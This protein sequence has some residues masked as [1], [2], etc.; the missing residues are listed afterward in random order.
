MAEFSAIT[1]TDHTFNP[2]IGCTK[3]GPGCDACYAEALMD[4]RYGRVK[5]GH[6]EERVRTKPQNWSKVRRWNKDAAAFTAEH[7][8]LPRVF[9]ASLADVFDNEVS[10]EWRAD[11]LALI[12]SARDLRWT[13]VTK[14][15]G[16]ARKML[17]ATWGDGWPHVAIAPTIVNQDEWDRDARKLRDLPAAKRG[18]SLEPLIG[19]I[20]MR[21][22]AAASDWLHWVIVGGESQQGKATPRPMHAEWARSLRDQSQCAGIAFHM[23]QMANDAPIPADLM[24]RDFPWID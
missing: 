24:I 21:L 19:Q 22:D 10:D 18:L 1:W 5:W 12:D 4:L 8:H 15:I 9:C 11:L 13:I 2:W 16:N 14:R 3:V 23:K 20:D 7:G 6:G 17:P